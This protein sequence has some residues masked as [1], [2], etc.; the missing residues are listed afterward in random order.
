LVIGIKKQKVMYKIK[1]KE[2]VFEPEVKR[3]LYMYNSA[4]VAIGLAAGVTLGLFLF[5]NPFKK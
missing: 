1:G 5:A 2:V 4:F 3:M